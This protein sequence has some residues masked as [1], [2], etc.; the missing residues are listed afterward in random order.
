M[1]TFKEFLSEGHP[2]KRTGGQSFSY[3]GHEMFNADK[4][5]WQVYDT[6]TP[7]SD[8]ESGYVDTHTS[9]TKPKSA[10]DSIQKIMV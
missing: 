4:R 7:K 10:I 2:V 9:M 6:T 1:K 3:R 5:E 8:E